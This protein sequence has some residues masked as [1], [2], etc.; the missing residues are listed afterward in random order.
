[1][2]YIFESKLKPFITGLIQQ[3][4][5][6]GYIYA[7]D[8]YHLKKFDEFC[9]S[10]FPDAASVTRDIASKWA[11]IRPTEGENYRN[12]RVTVLRQLSLYILSLGFEAYV[13][14]SNGR[15]VKPILYTSTFAHQ[16]TQSSLDITRK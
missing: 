1:M 15:T 9:V 12:R 13:P 8:E 10:F 3:K 11:L 14:R 5:K 2:K 16:K 6:D 4:R 7:D